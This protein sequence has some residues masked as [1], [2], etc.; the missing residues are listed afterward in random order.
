MADRLENYASE[1]DFQSAVMTLADLY[2]WWVMHVTT[3][4]KGQ[5]HLTSTSLSGWPDLVLWKPGVGV[6]YRELKTNRGR[7]SGA[8]QTVL[9]SLTEAGQDCAVWRPRDWALI[10][11]TLTG[12]LRPLRPTDEETP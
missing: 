4:Q 1:G 11:Q 2:G 3:S 7:L 10:E 8:Q 6:L 12:K 5:K 9:G